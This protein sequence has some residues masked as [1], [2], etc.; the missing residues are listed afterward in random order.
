MA[1]TS[2]IVKMTAQPGARDQVLAALQRAKPAAEAEEGTEAYTFHLDKGDPDALWVIELYTDDAA[3]GVHGGSEAVATL[4]GE[5]GPL[6]AEPPLLVM[7]EYV[8][9]FGLPL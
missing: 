4:F 5:V 1:K 9:G 7:G 6:L 2:M 3:L 8:D